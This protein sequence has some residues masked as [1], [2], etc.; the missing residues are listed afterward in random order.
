MLCVPC[1]HAAGWP[2]SD[3]SAR[4]T[5]SP[6]QVKQELDDGK[7]ASQAMQHVWILQQY[8]NRGTLYDAVDR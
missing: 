2:R 4:P 5:P 7:W 8:C 1:S 6:L 3:L